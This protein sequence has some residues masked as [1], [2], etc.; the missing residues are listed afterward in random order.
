MA[1]AHLMQC[2][3]HDCTYPSPPPSNPPLASRR[4]PP[5]TVPAVSVI[6]G[7]WGWT[8]ELAEQL[9]T[10]RMWRGMRQ[11]GVLPAREAGAIE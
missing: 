1:A 9:E 2:V 5:S 11:C 7:Y 8:R 4:Y 3:R 10:L 6:R